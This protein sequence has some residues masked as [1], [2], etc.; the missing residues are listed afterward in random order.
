MKKLFILLFF[1]SFPAYAAEIKMGA[2]VNFIDSA[3]VFEKTQHFSYITQKDNEFTN[4]L[5]I[6]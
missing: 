2:Y 6:L 5:I 4:W 1:V 3:Q